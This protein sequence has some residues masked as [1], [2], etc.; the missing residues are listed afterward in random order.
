MIEMNG[1]KFAVV[2]AH[3]HIWNQFGG[4]RFGTTATEP[5]GFG[6]VKQGTEVFR[7]LPPEYHDH[8]VPVE[9][10]LGYMD[11]NGVDKAVILQNPCYGD[12]RDYIRGV[13]E[14]YPGKF[15][16]VGIIDP[17]QRAE[18]A[19][20]MDILYNEYKFEGF[21]MEVP[22]VPFKMADPDYEFL[23]KKI[24]DM[25]ALV[26]LDLGWGTGP[27]DFNIEDFTAVMRKFPSMRTVLCHLG[28][29][30]LWDFSQPSP[31]L[32]L[33]KTLDLLDINRDNLMFDFSGLQTCEP[34]LEYPFARC[35][36]IVRTALKRCGPD[37]LMW[38]SDA[39]M[40]LRHCTYKQTLTCF[41]KYI[42]LADSDWKKILADNAE[43][44][45]FGK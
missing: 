12:N 14:K 16:S 5:L 26:V 33:Q 27:Y 2:D 24:T 11:T 43:K 37:K 13:C 3:T 6:M 7:M 40:I 28:V 19:C 20:Q 39:P 38:G 42:S 41:T 4:T 8:Q 23:W 21:K 17:R 35:L 34:S 10:L 44:V 22:D 30:R 9:I 18:V 25:G 1:K 45:Y 32:F 15:V 29:S 36:D 31:Y